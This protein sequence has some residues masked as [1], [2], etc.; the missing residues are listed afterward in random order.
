[1]TYG[2]RRIVIFVGGVPPLNC[3]KTSMWAYDKKAYLFG[4]FGPPPRKDIHMDV[5]HLFQVCF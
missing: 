5:E 2:L 4:G 3:D 1:V